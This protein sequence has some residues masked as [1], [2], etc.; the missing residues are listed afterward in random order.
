M[1][2]VIETRIDEFFSDNDE[3][4][5]LKI[6]VINQIITKVQDKRLNVSDVKEM[7]NAR[8]ACGVTEI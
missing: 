2:C 7:N 8:F 3:P 6:S 5:R 1:I 4:V